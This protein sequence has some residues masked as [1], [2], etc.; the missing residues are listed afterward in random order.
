MMMTVMSSIVMS[1]CVKFNPVSVPT[2]GTGML[3]K[4]LLLFQEITYSL[5]LYNAT[6]SMAEIHP[7]FYPLVFGVF[8]DI[9]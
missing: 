6:P 9:K 4:Y 1:V 8:S 5:L 2:V 3:I 7:H